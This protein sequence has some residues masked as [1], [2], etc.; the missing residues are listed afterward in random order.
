MYWF[1]LWG[2]FG[3]IRDSDIYSYNMGELFVNGI[4]RYSYKFMVFKGMLVGNEF[5]WIM[6][7]SFLC[8]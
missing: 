3:V 6:C 5:V 4:G 7:G 2:I 1:F 8:I